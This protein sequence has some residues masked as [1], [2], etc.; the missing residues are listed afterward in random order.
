LKHRRLL[1]LAPLAALAAACQTLPTHP[2]GT[3]P[4]ASRTLALSVTDNLAPVRGSGAEELTR[5]GSSTPAQLRRAHVLITAGDTAAAIE[6]LNRVLFG[7]VA[8]S[9]AEEAFARYLRARAL[10]RQ[11]RDEAAAEDMQR[12]A[13]LAVDG[14]LRALV[15]AVAEQ[16]R[17]PA[18]AAPAAAPPALASLLPRQRWS[19]RAPRAAGLLPLGKAYRLTLH[20]SD[21]L[22]RS[23]G[24]RA[25]AAQIYAIQEHHVGREGWSDIGYHF[26]IDRAGRIWE[27][28][29]LQWQGAHAGGDN[30]KGNIGVCLLG[31]FVRGS[32]GQEPSP[33]QLA[34]LERMLRHLCQAH[35]I[36][37]QGVYFHR[38]FRNTDCPGARLERAIAGILDRLHDLA[39]S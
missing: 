1:I 26:L 35:S 25:T 34:A 2:Y 30:N 18:P 39:K 16:P 17:K 8:P 9:A 12:A 4:A 10:A 20:H 32:G 11:G 27:G 5:L 29:S 13:A 36:G 28:R 7:A 22:M 37:P 3:G 38:T 24:E 23:D 6:T 31:R 14:D 19:A 33:A 21:V 15:G